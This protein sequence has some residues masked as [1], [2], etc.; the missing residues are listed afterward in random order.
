MIFEC[1]FYC[2]LTAN[3]FAGSIL[4]LKI[5]TVFQLQC[6]SYA[7][8]NRLDNRQCFFIIIWTHFIYCLRIIKQDLCIPNKNPVS[9]SCTPMII[10]QNFFWHIFTK[11]IPCRSYIR[12]TNRIITLPLNYVYCSIIPI[13]SM[14]QN[15]GSQT[16][17][18]IITRIGIVITHS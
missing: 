4:R 9:E 12:I 13:Y 16:W 6:H 11:I 17:I 3:K 14:I 1:Q 8:T 18:T 2:A 5:C 10:S 7:I 15:R